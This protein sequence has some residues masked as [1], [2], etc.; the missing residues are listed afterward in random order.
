MPFMGLTHH[1]GAD[2]LAISN[3]KL[4]ERSDNWVFYLKN[5]ANITKKSMDV[6]LLLGRFMP[7]RSAQNPTFKI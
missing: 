1:L 3:F 7:I 2:I 5:G 4:E 6:G